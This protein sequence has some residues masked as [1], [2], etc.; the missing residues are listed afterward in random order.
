MCPVGLTWIRG[1]GVH[2][3]GFVEAPVEI[4]KVLLM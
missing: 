2:G 3:N 1:P 4:V